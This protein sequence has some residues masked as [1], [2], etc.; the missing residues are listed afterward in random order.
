MRFLE[1]AHLSLFFSQRGGEGQ[2]TRASPKRERERERRRRRRR[3][4]LPKSKGSK[5]LF[6]LSFFGVSCVA[7][8]STY[9]QKRSL[10]LFR[11]GGESTI[12]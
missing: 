5:G 8:N 6:F 9:S 7:K 10:L 4:F 2:H 3:V 1:N 12:K 11:K